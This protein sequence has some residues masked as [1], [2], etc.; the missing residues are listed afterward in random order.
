MEKKIG[1]LAVPAVSEGFRQLL[2][3]YTMAINKKYGRTGSLFRQ[4]TKKK[5]L[6]GNGEHPF[7]CFQYIH[8]NPLTAGL[9]GRMEDWEFSSFVDYLG[10]RKGSLCDQNLAYKLLD[11]SR[12]TFHDESYKVISQEKIERLF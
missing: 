4:K 7:I 2:S 8:Q 1:P 10:L 11:L 12:D 5:L 3:S 9:V 6:E